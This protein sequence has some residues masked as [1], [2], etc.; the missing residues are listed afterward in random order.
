MFTRPLSDNPYA[1]ASNV[2][3]PATP[4]PPQRSNRFEQPVTSAA[5]STG[6]I[7]APQ[8]KPA[9]QGLAQAAAPSPSPAATASTQQVK[10]LPPPS[11]LGSRVNTY[12]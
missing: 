9:N 7:A 6:T 12:A 2:Q 10:P 1:Y 5:A 4:H 3:L 8:E 11:A